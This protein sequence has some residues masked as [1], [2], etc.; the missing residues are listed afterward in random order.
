MILWWIAPVS[1]RAWPDLLER[2]ECALG[3]VPREAVPPQ[4]AVEGDQILPAH[5][6]GSFQNVQEASRMFDNLRG[7]HERAPTHIIRHIGLM[8]LNHNYLTGTVAPG[9]LTPQQPA[10]EWGALYI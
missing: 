4:Q 2:L 10:S 8:T 3:G 7:Y 6:L 9:P 5:R 1:N